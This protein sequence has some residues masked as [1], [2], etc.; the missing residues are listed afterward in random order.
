MDVPRIDLDHIAAYPSTPGARRTPLRFWGEAYVANH[1]PAV[2]HRAFTQALA[3]H[4][5]IEHPGVAETEKW[6]AMT[7]V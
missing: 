7:A 3:V 1:Q 2:A 4:K 5:R 6:F